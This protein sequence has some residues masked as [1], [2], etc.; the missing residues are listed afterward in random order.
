MLF[1]SVLKAGHDGGEVHI[2][3]TD[4]KGKPQPPTVKIEPEYLKRW[5]A[6]STWD[7]TYAME[8]TVPGKPNPIPT[9]K[10]TMLM[11]LRPKGS[12]V[13]TSAQTLEAD[14]MAQTTQVAKAFKVFL[15][16]KEVPSLPKGAKH[17]HRFSLNPN[18]SETLA[19]K[20]RHKMNGSVKRGVKTEGMGGPEAFL[21]ACAQVLRGVADTM[22]SYPTQSLMIQSYIIGQ[23]ERP[24]ELMI[25]QKPEEG[26]ED[27]E[28]YGFPATEE[29]LEFE[30]PSP[31]RIVDGRSSRR[32]SS[33]R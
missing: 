10:R 9:P 2:H 1:E 30:V 24:P 27:D 22:A 16:G 23:F 28:N 5:T 33:R 15:A 21:Q 7:D 4:A 25:K 31:P 29:S 6:V 11:E 17:L 20:G 18:Q 14:L 32:N 3:P 12:M 19:E 26:G 8:D 13:V